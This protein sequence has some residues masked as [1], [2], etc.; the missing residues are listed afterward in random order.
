MA[1][2]K[3][4]LGKYFSS[5]IFNIVQKSSLEESKPKLHLNRSTLE[6]TKEKIFNIQ[7]E[8][9]IGRNKNKELY[10]NN[11]AVKRKI[12]YEKMYGSDIFNLKSK[13][14]ERRSGRHHMP[15]IDNRSTIF[16]EMKNNE[17]YVKNIKEYT[18]EKR[19]YFNNKKMTNI[20]EEK[21]IDEKNLRYIKR[22]RPDVE[23]EK[24]NEIISRNKNNSILDFRK[25]HPLTLYTNER[26]RFVD[27]DEFHENNCKINKQIQF[28]SHLFSDKDNNY[29]KSKEEIKEIISRIN[30][31]KN[32][33]K[34]NYN[35]L[36][37]PIIR[38][39]RKKD[40]ENN[41]SMNENH[42]EI[43]PADM[44]WDSLQSQVMFSPNYSKNL[45]KNFG[46]NPTA[47]QR[48]LNQFADSDNKDTLSGQQKNDVQKIKYLR[49]P[50]KEEKRIKEEQKK[51]D[52]M[53]ENNPYLSERQKNEIKMNRSVL[54]LRDENE[55]DN[56]Q[57]DLN[58]FLKKGKKEKNKI[59][60]KVNHVN[61]NQNG[62]ENK[63]NGKK[64]EYYDY[65]IT[66]GI[67]G[68][69][70]ENYT[71]HEI[72]NLFGKKGINVYEVH[73][74]NFGKGKKYNTINIKIAGNNKNDE[75]NKKI[76]LIQDELIKN[77]YKLKIE[78][79]NK[80]NKI[81]NIV[82][83]PGGKLAIM[84]DNVNN[85]KEEEKFKIMSAEYKAKRGFTKQ[86]MGINYAYK[87][88]NQL[89]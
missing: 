30:K 5:D 6:N 71:E 89:F 43:R 47:Y 62:N 10:R 12:N 39:N 52:K 67:K 11:S 55:W 82:N 69:N 80:S 35:I 57:I 1:S 50:I 64:L 76:K 81:K 37:Q 13:S 32:Y 28:E 31:A 21:N 40:Y 46:P 74:N 49:K 27:I 73:K 61:S 2:R 18:E 9:R 17:E 19:S 8:K 83:N 53:F 79:G 44:K 60:D 14:V 29:P 88:P 36:G 34:N 87:N 66:Y 72:K 70:F 25:R 78:K 77:N 59:T 15:F 75:L 22:R 68:N 48:R 42:S 7:K 41:T 58:E 51:I 45:Y 26:R 4:V 23:I 38:V 63:N 86:F 65:T 20:T 24:S 16:E 33:Y 85:K 84:K 3:E 54:D 56:K